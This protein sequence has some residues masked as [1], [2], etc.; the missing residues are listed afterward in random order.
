MD[1]IREAAKKKLVGFTEREI[2]CFIE[3][4]KYMAGHLP[5]RRSDEW[6]REQET[7]RNHA[8]LHADENLEF[9]KKVTGLGDAVEQLKRPHRKETIISTAVNVF[10]DEA[11]ADTETRKNLL[12]VIGATDNKDLSEILYAIKIGIQGFNE[13]HSVQLNF[14]REPDNDNRWTFSWDEPLSVD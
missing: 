7:K 13:R 9:W 6:Y 2:D 5:Q 8:K 11:S 4:A 3:G 12:N 1:N 14:Q 10:L